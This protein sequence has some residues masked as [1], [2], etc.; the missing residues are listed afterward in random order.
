MMRTTQQ[1]PGIGRASYVAGALAL[2]ASI[3]LVPAAGAQQ[4]SEEW[5]ER[6]RRSDSRRAVHCEVR[7]T[8]LPATGSLDVNA[9]PNGGI[10]VEGWDRNEVLVRA[11]VQAQ[12]PT[13]A[14]ARAIASE[15]RVEAGNGRVRAEGP[16]WNESRDRGW[17]VSY[18]V[19]VPRRTDLAMESTNGGIR[20]QD[21]QGRLEAT[22]TNGGISLDGVS[23]DV[24]GRTTN[25][26]LDVRVAR[27]GW[28]GAGLDLRT[29]NG[30]IDLRLPDGVSARLEA[31]T[32]NGGISTDFPITVQGRIG[33]R[34]EADLGGGGP[35][36]RLSTTNGRVSIRRN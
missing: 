8:R 14:E 16:R 2:L 25:G 32:V 3:T 19:F 21:V 13:E 7:E 36:I 18:E 29:T 30:G 23:G 22:T 11:R 24:R 17:S 31:E 9:R 12:A 34:I 4:T 27:A 26:G 28:T 6:C 10:Q 1:R 5:L 20:V 35:P 33:R 15:I